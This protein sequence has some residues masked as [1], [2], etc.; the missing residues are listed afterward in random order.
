MLSEYSSRSSS[1]KKWEH[2][3]SGRARDLEHEKKMIINRGASSDPDILHVHASGTRRRTYFEFM[4]TSPAH[5]L[6]RLK[7][8]CPKRLSISASTILK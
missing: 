4:Y 7:G 8:R 5:V 2:I 1:I 6:E 3:A